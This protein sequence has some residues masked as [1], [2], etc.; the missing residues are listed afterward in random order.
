MFFGSNKG[1]LAVTISGD[2]AG[3]WTD[4]D[5]GDK[6]NLITLIQKQY[7]LGFREALEEAAKLVNYIPGDFKQRLNEVVKAKTDSTKI[8]DE[9]KLKIKYATKLASEGKEINGTPAEKYLKEVR[10]ID[11]KDWPKDLKYHAGVYSKLNGGKNP[12]LLA[13][14]RDKDNYIQSVQAIFLNK[15]TGEKADVECKK[16]TFGSIKGAVFSANTEN[17]STKSAI[18]CEGPEDALSILK[19]TSGSKIYACLGKSNL[20]NLDQTIVNKF[21][22]I[23]LALD[24]D[25]KKPSEMPEILNVASRLNDAGKEILLSQPNMVKQDYNDLLKTKGTKEVANIIEK[26]IPFDNNNSVKE[27]KVDKQNEKN[28]EKE[29]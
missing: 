10:G 6:G 13:I 7:G 9:Q 15:D 18:V 25:G 19:S 27:H 20:N 4:F 16:Q 28:M 1:S 24:N 22:K 14:A 3:T 17:Y 26:S 21:E 12:A 2:Y 23:T 29:I 5:S 11:L 8:T